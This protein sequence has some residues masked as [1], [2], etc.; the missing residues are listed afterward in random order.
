VRKGDDFT[1]FIVPKV[2]KIRNLKL[3]D[4]QGPVQACSG[5]ILPLPWESISLS[6]LIT[7]CG[8]LVCSGNVAAGK[9][10]NVE[11]HFMAVHEDYISKYPDNSYIR[12][13]SFEDLKRGL[14]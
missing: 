2:E 12:R 1:T 9:K 8:C 6:V 10:C 5:K 7:K 11:G 3:L 4:L 14:Q 13:T